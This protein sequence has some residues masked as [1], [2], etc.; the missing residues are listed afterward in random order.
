VGIITGGIRTE[1]HRL[2]AKEMRKK[3]KTLI[4][5]GSCACYGG[6]PALANLSTVEELLQKVYRESVS[7]E[8]N[9]IPKEEIPPLTDR[10]YAIHEFVPVDMKLPG[11]PTT[12]EIFVEAVTALLEGKP[13]QLSGKSVC[14]EC[15][16]IREK[17]AVSN[18]KRPLEP[19]TFTPGEPMNTVRCIMEQ[20]YLCLGPATK[21]GCGGHEGTPR[22]IRA[23]MPCRGCFGP[24]SD[25]A[26]PMVDMMG[27]LASIGLDAK[28]I[29]DRAATFNR[30]AGAQGRLR[31][32]PSKGGKPS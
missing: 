30:F 31:P 18:L 32:I 21:A 2:L 19:I 14:D 1:E 4:A 12:P 8:S 16:F 13:F 24:L 7:T 20:G 29:E 3:C 26:N 15:P 6:V 17:K 27:A 25:N 28:Q 9:G 11:C 23:Y 22:C 5:M 10:V